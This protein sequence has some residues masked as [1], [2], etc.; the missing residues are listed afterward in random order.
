MESLRTTVYYIHAADT[1]YM[2]NHNDVHNCYK[3]Q[4]LKRNVERIFDRYGTF[5]LSDDDD[6][7]NIRVQ[8]SKSN[9]K[10]LFHMSSHENWRFPRSVAC[11][12]R[13]HYSNIVSS[14]LRLLPFSDLP[15][16]RTTRLN[17]GKHGWRVSDLFAGLLSS[18]FKYF[19]GIGGRRFTSYVQKI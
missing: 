14:R 5:W 1:M 9:N 17:N 19:W 7:E 3:A 4:H 12:L 15:S 2:V 16:S 13:V 8:V 6:G 11:L 10:L 18:H